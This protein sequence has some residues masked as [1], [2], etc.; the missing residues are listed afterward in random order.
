MLI[1]GGVAIASL[2]NLQSGFRNINRTIDFVNSTLQT[3]TVTQQ[4]IDSFT[5]ADNSVYHVSAQ[6][7]AFENGANRASYEI[8][9]MVYRD[10]GG[11]TLGGGGTTAVH[12]DESEAAWDAT[13]GVDGNDL[14][15]LV[16]GEA[17]TT[18]EWSCSMQYMSAGI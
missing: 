18:I 13:F 15:V 1:A 12:T 7:A 9:V 3:T 11:A 4:A 10:G 2:Q 17:A 6:L 5:L 16:T 8:K 14:T